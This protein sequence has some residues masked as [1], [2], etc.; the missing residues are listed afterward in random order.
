MELKIMGLT[1]DL[2]PAVD[3]LAERW[4]IVL[5]KTAGLSVTLA[6]STAPLMIRRADMTGDIA[7]PT[8]AAALRG[9]TAWVAHA[10]NE[11]HF[12][13][14]DANIPTTLGL[15]LDADGP[16]A[17]TTAEGRRLLQRVAA[18]GFTAVTVVTH[19]PQPAWADDA[20]LLG[21][22]WQTV[23]TAPELTAQAHFSLYAEQGLA[24][25]QGLMLMGAKAAADKPPAALWVTAAFADGAE[26]PLRAL[27]LGLQ[28]A[29]EAA[30]SG[31]ASPAWLA[32]QFWLMQHE[33]W[34]GFFALDQFDNFKRRGKA[35]RHEANPS[36]QLLYMD[37][38]VPRFWASFKGVDAEKHYRVLAD[39][40]ASAVTTPL[41]RPLYAYAVA[42]ARFLSAKAHVLAAIQDAY[43]NED[44]SEMAGVVTE[45][46]AL[47][48]ELDKVHATR[49][50][51]WLAE[52]PAA[53]WALLDSRFGGLKQRLLT[54][55]DRLTAWQS[56]TLSVLPELAEAMN[57]TAAAA[58]G[59]V[60][61]AVITGQSPA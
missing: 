26:T 38:L 53:G 32:D 14:T 23:P 6:P 42:L 29:A 46:T 36:K 60:D 25:N 13:Y 49:Q 51:L 52:H 17:L 55:V 37:W 40:L 45:L 21:L 61:Y 1:A 57:M 5:T 56:G 3:L 59:P 39:K 30:Y 47:A 7:Y 24:P 33:D 27:G 34:D 31:D 2:Q 15:V 44:R 58:D 43:R 9:I 22:T 19:A 50:T 54:A 41:T 10:Q 16:A 18:L 20:P 8:P 4:D 48:P 12:T 35:N 11:R 28:A